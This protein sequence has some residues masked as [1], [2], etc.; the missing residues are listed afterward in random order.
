M[1]KIYDQ[2]L[3][4]HFNSLKEMSLAVNAQL[5]K[6]M[7]ALDTLNPVLAQEVIDG[8]QEINQFMVDIER[9][10][11]LIVATEQPVA[12]DLR[13]IFAVLLASVDLER[14]G[15][16]TRSIAEQIIQ[17]KDKEKII[18]LDDIVDEM[19]VT[20]QKMLLDVIA[21]FEKRDVEAAKTIARRDDKID[22]GLQEVLRTSKDMLKAQEG[23]TDQGVSYI[24][25]AN[26]LERIGDYVTNLCE[27]VVYLETNEIIEL[28]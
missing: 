2:K 10:S 20:A 4:Q 15:D 19:A 16:H 22:E 1:R 6:A 23:Q 27:R 28:A 24:R 18:V 12:A 3:E 8:D 14:I 11:Y 7:L 26:N 13:L 17:N 9:E 5:E 25:I 21:V